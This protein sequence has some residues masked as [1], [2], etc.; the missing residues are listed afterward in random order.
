MVSRLTENSFAPS[1]LSVA[2]VGLKARTPQNDPG[3]I[4]DPPVWVP[5][6]AGT[7]RSATA[8]A[9]PLDDPPGVRPRSWGL[10]VIA[11][12]PWAANSI[13]SA[14]PR[15]IAPAA[16]SSATAAAS[17]AGRWPA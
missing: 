8:A 11:I 2:Q 17:L 16:R 9:E 15:M 10:R 7:I 1:G 13:V 6:A 4:I 3:R 12:R 5:S 14:L